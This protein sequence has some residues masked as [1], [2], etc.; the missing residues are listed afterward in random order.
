MVKV[1][2]K[3]ILAG[4]M[5]FLL[6]CSTLMNSGLTVFAAETS[7]Q[8]A[9]V[10]EV[11]SESEEVKETEAELMELPKLEEVKEQ[12]EESEI[13][14]AEDITIV[15]GENFDA[16]SDYTGL[17]IDNEKV[18]VSFVK[19]EDE[20]GQKFDFNVPG[21]YQAFYRVDPVSGHPSYQIVRRIIVTEKEGSNQDQ[22]NQNNHSEDDSSAEDGEA[23]PDSEGEI[24]EVLTQEP[25]IPEDT[26]DLMDVTADETGMFFS[27]VPAA[28]E[29]AKGTNVNLETGELIPYPSSIGNYATTYFTVNGKVAYCLE[30]KKASPPSSD[31]VAN[32]FESNL[33]LQK[34]LY[35]GYGGPGD[36]TDSYM[37]SFDWKTKYVFTHLAASYSY[38]GMDGFYGC[39]FDDIKASGVWGYIQHIYSLEAPP[40]AAISLSPEAVKA[41]ENGDIQ[42]TEAFKLDGDHRN[43][44]TL[45][46]PEGVTYH[47]GGTKKT[48]S[49]KISGGTSFYFSAPKTVTGTWNSG[50]LAGQ[51]G[52]Q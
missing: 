6:S 10:Q 7:V 3:Q 31:Y 11:K 35:Y 37:P 5:A 23:D 49:V 47:S 29:N 24:K 51:M 8:T 45:N 20:A 46:L 50:K 15:A 12:L 40:T 22:Q 4:A 27:V 32:V 13:V 17:K 25:E 34:V 1:K 48:G 33:E 19:A 28:M 44:I 41:Y 21:S 38:C 42:R 9:A 30:S 16:K 43:Y 26:T 2:R 14:T 52:T 18:K 39:T 36:I